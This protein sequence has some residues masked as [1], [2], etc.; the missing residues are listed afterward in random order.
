MLGVGTLL[1]WECQYQHENF[2]LSSGKAEAAEGSNQVSIEVLS[3]IH[4]IVIS[5]N[6]REANTLK[7]NFSPDPAKS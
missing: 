2:L 6:F 7:N 3:L 4:L 5:D 1:H